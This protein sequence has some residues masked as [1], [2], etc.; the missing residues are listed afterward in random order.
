MARKDQ[1]ILLISDNQPPRE[2][3]ASEISVSAKEFYAAASVGLRPEKIFEIYTF[4]Y[5]GEVRVQHNDII[6]NVIRTQ[7]WNT[8]TRLVCDWHSNTV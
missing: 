4:E 5:Q 3:Y 2:I 1:V 8:K 6:Y 7:T